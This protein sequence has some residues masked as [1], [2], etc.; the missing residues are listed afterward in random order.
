MLLRLS[1]TTFKSYIILGSNV[2]VRTGLVVN[3]QSV[4]L[5]TF[6]HQPTE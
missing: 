5:T 3:L 6:D 1:P 2:T 4:P